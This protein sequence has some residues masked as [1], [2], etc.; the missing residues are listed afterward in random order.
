MP[1]AKLY[2]TRP[3]S[4]TTARIK[5]RRKNQERMASLTCVGNFS[6]FNAVNIIVKTAD[7][8][9]NSKGFKMVVLG[10]SSMN[11][12]IA[13]NRVKY[14]KWLVFTVNRPHPK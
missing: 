14:L 4:V 6:T 2:L 10:P 9:H 12:P 11:V 7:K 8:L 3:V 5:E 13:S 1:H